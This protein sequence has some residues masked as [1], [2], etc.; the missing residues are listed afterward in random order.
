MFQDS[1]VSNLLRIIQHM[2]PTT[3]QPSA[4]KSAKDKLASKFPGLA[5]PN[6]PSFGSLSDDKIEMKKEKKRKRDDAE[7][8]HKPDAT[9]AGDSV[10]DAMAFLESFAPSAG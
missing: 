8:K 2:K 1:F 9:L 7:E 4:P 5:I 10:E 6:D 3:S